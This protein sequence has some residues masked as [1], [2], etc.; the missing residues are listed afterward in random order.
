MIRTLLVLDG[1]LMRGALAF[2]LSTQSDIEV[3]GEFDDLG[4]AATTMAA[5][6]PDVTVV[7]LNVRDVSHLL[8]AGDG[9]HRILALAD[10]VKAAQL[11]TVMV[12][13]SEKIGFIGI[14]SPPLK[15]IQSIRKLAR[16]ETVL[17]GALVASALRSTDPLTVREREILTI[18]AEGWPVREI[19]TKFGVAPGTIRNHL[20]R[21]VAKCGARNRIQAV[22]RAQESGWI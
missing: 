5:E 1:R 6:R 3:V 18:A 7:D 13:H 16:G 11:A 20:S 22:K 21:I 8:R 9:Q 12:R 15:V 2:V 4:G 17:D 10:P 19:A 14:G